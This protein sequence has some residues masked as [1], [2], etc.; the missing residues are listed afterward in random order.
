MHVVSPTHVGL[1]SFC[2][3]LAWSNC[4]VTVSNSTNGFEVK[5]TCEKEIIAHQQSF[6]GSFL[7]PLNSN[8]IWV[9]NFKMVD[10][11]NTTTHVNYRLFLPLVRNIGVLDVLYNSDTGEWA[12]SFLP[13]QGIN[14][15][16]R[17]LFTQRVFNALYTVC[18]FPSHNASMYTLKLY[19]ISLQDLVVNNENYAT[20]YDG[21]EFTN[22]VYANLGGRRQNQHFYFVRDGIVWKITPSEHG[23]T[24]SPTS[25]NSNGC[26]N[27][28]CTDIDFISHKSLLLVQCVC[29]SSNQSCTPYWMYYDVYNEQVTSVPS[30]EGLPFHCPEYQTTVYVHTATHHYTIHG[31]EYA[32][33][34][35]GFRDGFCSGN[36]FGIWFAYQ[37]ND[38][39]IFVTDLSVPN[40]STPVFYMVSENGC[41]Q[42]PNCNP[43]SNVSDIL[44]IQEFD[45][46]SDQVIAK[47][48]KPKANFSVLFEVNSS[49]PSFFTLLNIPSPRVPPM[50]PSPSLA[51]TPEDEEKTPTII[52]AVSATAAGIVVLAVLLGALACGLLFYHDK[53]PCSRFSI[54]TDF[55]LPP[56]CTTQFTFLIMCYCNNYPYRNRNSRQN[57]GVIQPHQS[58]DNNGGRDIVSGRCAPVQTPNLMNPISVQEQFLSRRCT[59]EKRNDLTHKGNLLAQDQP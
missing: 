56:S 36:A 8:N 47:G 4:L 1:I 33:E 44:M 29:C 10:Q 35:D 40:N 57:G 28:T 34:G 5:I 52:I 23:R 48:I 38:G 19:E 32:L 20:F 13:L 27:Y 42:G 59:E 53:C 49:Q 14:E 6:T 3:G 22:V 12:T 43:I 18:I 45:E 26:L 46:T 58:E 21:F 31:T 50:S 41:L 2:I 30:N 39:R 15:P 17:T 16:C 25:L 37:D 11:N 9:E 24:S 51:T 55:T 54:I 7:S